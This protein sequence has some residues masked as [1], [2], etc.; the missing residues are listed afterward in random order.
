MFPSQNG[1]P[2]AHEI[3]P[4]FSDHRSFR[5]NHHVL[6]SMSFQIRYRIR[7][8]RLAAAAVA[9]ADGSVRRDHRVRIGC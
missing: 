1:E 8:I 9:A 3:T 2:A 4:W 6:R 5:P 7:R